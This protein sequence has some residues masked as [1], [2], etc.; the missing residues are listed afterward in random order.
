VTHVHAVGAS[1]VVGDREEAAAMHD[2]LG[3]A[4]GRVPTVAAKANF[5]N[6]GAASGLVECVTSLLAMRHGTLFPLLNYETADPDCGILPA[7]RG[8]PAGDICLSSAV[9]PQGQA[10]ALVLRGWPATA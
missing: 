6:L 7:R 2:V 9:T 10:G 8:A 3:A 5:G 4:A 1:T